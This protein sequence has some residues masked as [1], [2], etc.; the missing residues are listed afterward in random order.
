MFRA[1]GFWGVLV[2]SFGLRVSFWGF[3]VAL[4]SC[5]RKGFL[6]VFF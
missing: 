5:L 6:W 2:F 4:Q 3:A 1:L